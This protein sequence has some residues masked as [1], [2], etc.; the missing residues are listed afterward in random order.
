MRVSRPRALPSFFQN[1]PA[2]PVGVLEGDG[3]DRA[4]EVALADA[5]ARWTWS[6]NGPA[7]SSA[8]ASAGHCRPLVVSRAT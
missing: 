8:T 5:A 1:S 4:A 3:V 6:S 7:G 2:R